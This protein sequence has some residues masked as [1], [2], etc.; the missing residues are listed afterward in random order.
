MSEDLT[1]MLESGKA[2]DSRSRPTYVDA[3]KLMV[4]VFV[5]HQEKRRVLAARIIQPAAGG[6]RILMREHPTQS[7]ERMEAM[8]RQCRRHIL[9][10]QVSARLREGL[11]LFLKCLLGL[12]ALFLILR[13]LAYAVEIPGDLNR[14]VLPAIAAIL[15]AVIFVRALVLGLRGEAVH[16]AAAAERL[17]LSQSTHNRIATAIALLRSGD[18]SPFAA[19]AIRRRL[20]I[21]R[22]TPVRSAACRPRHLLV[23][24]QRCLSGAQPGHRSDRAL[25]GSRTT[26]SWHGQSRPI[27]NRSAGE[28]RFLA[29]HARSQG[30]AQATARQPQRALSGRRA[31]SPQR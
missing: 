15:A 3:N 9:M 1:K 28:P 4:V 22:K 29:P 20:R 8:L 12:A 21:S 2:K 24:A 5:Q 11:D 23:A 16:M 26:V 14:V 27:G 17:D 25:P 10:A 30:R 7:L 19:A 13:V 18:E 6:G 31:S